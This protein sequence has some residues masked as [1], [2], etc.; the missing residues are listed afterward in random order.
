[1]EN[2]KAAAIIP[3]STGEITH[4]AA[5]LPIVPQETIEK[6]P[7]AGPEARCDSKLYEGIETREQ[8]Y[9]RTK[10]IVAR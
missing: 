5:I 1:M 9:N 10:K 8:E 4:E 2:K 7:A 3:P 6:P